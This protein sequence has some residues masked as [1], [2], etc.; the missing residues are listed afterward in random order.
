[1]SSHVVLRNMLSC[2][3]LS[4][5]SCSFVQF[6]AFSPNRSRVVVD[7]YSQTK[8]HLLGALSH[9]L[10]EPWNLSHSTGNG[11]ALRINLDDGVS[12]VNSSKFYE[13]LREITNC[14]TLSYI[15]SYASRNITCGL[16]YLRYFHHPNST[17][18]NLSWFIDQS[19]DS[20]LGLARHTYFRALS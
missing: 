14:W 20:L 16:S 2:S 10:L 1:M 19:L 12:I 3:S 15:C 6:T 8:H 9:L 17:G 4:T 13:T 7:R 11:K 5:H 18:E